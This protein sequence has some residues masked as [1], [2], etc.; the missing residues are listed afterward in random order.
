MPQDSENQ[1][2]MQVC[3]FKKHSGWRHFLVFSFPSFTFAHRFSNTT[4]IV[5]MKKIFILPAL[6]VVFIACKN[7]SKK[8]GAE[9]N[10]AAA[11]VEQPAAPAPISP[12]EAGN[13]LK[14]AQNTIEETKSLQKEIDAL[15]D[16]VKKSKA[17]QIANLRSTLEGMAEKE[18]YFAQELDAALKSAAQPGAGGAGGLVGDKSAAIQ[19]AAQSLKGYAEDLKQLKEQ[20]KDLSKQ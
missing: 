20:V 12:E 3:R 7:D 15:S 16:A 19:D 17:D 9:T 11:P 5:R 4:N 2:F 18:A 1:F 14:E 10:P 13:V 8:D 6:L